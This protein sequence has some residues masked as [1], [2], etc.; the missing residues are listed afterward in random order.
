MISPEDIISAIEVFFSLEENVRRDEIRFH[1]IWVN[2][3]NILFEVAD[4][5]RTEWREILVEPP[6][7]GNTPILHFLGRIPPKIH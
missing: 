2:D 5:Y 3:V 4:Y 7:S 1:L 6:H